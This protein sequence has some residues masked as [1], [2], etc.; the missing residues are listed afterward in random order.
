MA[1]TRAETKSG[2]RN[3]LLVAVV[4]VIAF[5]GACGGSPEPSAVPATAQCRIDGQ[6]VQTESPPTPV[7]KASFEA[8]RSDEFFKKER[9]PD[10]AEAAQRVVDGFTDDDEGNVQLA[11]LRLAISN[12]RLH[13]EPD[14]QRLFTLIVEEPHHPKRADAASWLCAHFEGRKAQLSEADHAMHAGAALK[15][16][17]RA[18]EQFGAAEARYRREIQL[19]AVAHKRSEEAKAV[20]AGGRSI[21]GGTDCRDVDPAA[22]A[23]EAEYV[24][25]FTPDLAE[26][27]GR[28]ESQLSTIDSVEATYRAALATVPALRSIVEDQRNVS[29][30]SAER[31][32]EVSRAVSASSSA[33]SAFVK[34]LDV[35]RDT[36]QDPFVEWS[37]RRE[38]VA[39][40]ARESARKRAE[41]YLDAFVNGPSE[42]GDAIAKVNGLATVMPKE[43]SA[44][45][46]SKLPQMRERFCAAKQAFRN[47]FSEQQFTAATEWHCRTNAPYVSTVQG[48]PIEMKEI[49]TKAFAFACTIKE[50]S[51]ATAGAGATPSTP[52]TTGTGKLPNGQCAGSGDCTAGFHCSPGG[53]CISDAAGPP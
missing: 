11:E 18:L 47:Q 50:P 8:T 34:S 2:S 53:W 4:A 43:L 3:A 38:Q 1:R 19:R 14:S 26:R 9:W 37:K 32:A 41:A 36:Q 7:G 5:A 22:S 24:A 51:R 39:A 12:Y 42:A 20:L 28:F 35:Y 52:P 30:W 10:A 46:T 21:C 23:P 31:R 48:Q 17:K 13:R 49:C 27:F 25:L 45:Y 33:V 40:A 44:K 16:A 29:A 15:A 6:V